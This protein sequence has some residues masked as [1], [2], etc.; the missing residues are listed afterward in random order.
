MSPLRSLGIV[1]CFDRHFPNGPETH[2]DVTPTREIARCRILRHTGLGTSEGGKI[3]GGV[4]ANT[5][6][7]KHSTL[8]QLAPGFGPIMPASAKQDTGF[9]KTEV[10]KSGCR[11][12]GKSSRV[13]RWCGGA[14]MAVLPKAKG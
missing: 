10:G 11:P 2:N 4:I 14:A 5:I 12:I 7:L 1:D 13:R 3:H 6:S 9:G 8:T